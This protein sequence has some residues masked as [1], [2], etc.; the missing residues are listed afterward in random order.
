MK[1]FAVILA[2]LASP[3]SAEPTRGNIVD[4]M[5]AARGFSEKRCP[6]FPGESDSTLAIANILSGDAGK[7]FGIHSTD[8][9]ILGQIEKDPGGSAKLWV[10]A[11]MGFSGEN[12]CEILETV[13][14][15]DPDFIQFFADQMK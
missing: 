6:G 8:A 12:A 10:N 4:F 14:T 9:N 13:L 5:D 2:F 3:L 15:G 11:M 7:T 1:K